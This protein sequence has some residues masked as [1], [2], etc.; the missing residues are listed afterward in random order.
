MSMR[1]EQGQKICDEVVAY[2][3]EKK[4]RVPMSKAFGFEEFDNCLM[5]TMHNHASGRRP[6]PFPYWK[7]ITDFCKEHGY[8]L[9]YNEDIWHNGMRETYP[10]IYF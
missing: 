7:E 3:K 4:I 10:S 5:V 1:T 9:G 6:K 8:Q 2:F